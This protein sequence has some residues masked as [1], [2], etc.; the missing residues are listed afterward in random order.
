M[1]PPTR[2]L[3]VELSFDRRGFLRALGGLAAALA[4]P[5]KAR[6]SAFGLGG[7]PKPAA[8]VFFTDHERATLV[9]LCDRIVPP[10]ADPGAGAL[11]AAKYVENLL[12]AFEA[13]VPRLFTRGPF[14]GRNPFPDL[15]RG[16]PSLRL[17]RNSFLRSVR[18]SRVQELYW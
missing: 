13:P 3:A 14:S 6:A 7:G 12:L 10:D 17:P 15:R 18:P 2:C 16:V 5:V 11:G 8:P 9:A 4:A 1:A